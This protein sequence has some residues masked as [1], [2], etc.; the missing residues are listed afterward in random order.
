MHV[1]VI[2]VDCATKAQR[3]GLAVG[4]WDGSHMTLTSCTV[5]SDAAPPDRTIA[6]LTSAVTPTLLALDAPLGWPSLLGEHLSHHAAGNAINADPAEL[7]SRMTDRVVQQRLGKRPLEVGADRIARTAFYTLKLLSR[8][9][10]IVPRPFALAW[11]PDLGP[12]VHG[13]EVYPAAT[14]VAHGLPSSGYKKPG[15]MDLRR[16]ILG[17]LEEQ[18]ALP[19]DT[20]MLIANPH[21]LDAAICLLAAVDFLVGK[22][23]KP[24][25]LEVARKEGWIWVRPDSERDR[26]TFSRKN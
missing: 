11:A 20:S 6:D 19:H 8:V 14:L 13:I 1:R 9:T 21:A 18:L 12:G 7:F 17:G 10:E 23:I 16:R 25:D 24:A 15:R 4:D 3:V 2:G 5:C 26:M 22:A